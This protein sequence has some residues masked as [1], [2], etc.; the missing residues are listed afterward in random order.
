[1]THAQIISLLGEADSSADT[2]G[3]AFFAPQTSSEDRKRVLEFMLGEKRYGQMVS[4][5][6]CACLNGRVDM[7][8]TSADYVAATG[9]NSTINTRYF[10]LFVQTALDCGISEAKF[11]PMIFLAATSDRKSRLYVWKSSSEWYLSK[12]AVSDYGR[13][14]EYLEKNDTDFKLFSIL[15][16]ADRERAVRDLTELAMFGK[17][18]N[19]VAARKILRGYKSE[20]TAYVR[21]LYSSLKND[22]KVA[23]VR[24]LLTLKNDPDVSAFLS[25]LAQTEKSKSVL[26]LLGDRTLQTKDIG[27]NPDRRRVEA[28]FY[29]A[30]VLGTPFSPEQFKEKLI[31]SPFHE[32]ADKLFF[33]V[34]RGGNLTDIAVVDSGKIF[35]IENKPIE[36]PADCE[37]RVLHPAELN[38]KTEFI[39]RLNIVQPFE[40]VK[41]KVYVASEADKSNNACFG[42]AGMMTEFGEFKNAM[43][44][45]GFRALN[46]DSESFTSQVGICRN[47]ILCVVNIAPFDFSSAPADFAVRVQSVKFYRERDVVRLGGK[48]FVDGVAPLSLAR[49]DARTF[50]EFMYSAYELMGCK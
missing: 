25:E 36:L 34:Y 3:R 26:K 45:I 15:I 1:M 35:D 42:I 47:G 33:G 44:K 40:Q 50:S 27:E 7:K 48:Q 38:Y 39:K 5:M 19:K 11:I 24:L 14:W 9:G 28:F 12:L 37:V 8:K 2:A 6:Y 13:A 18:V 46:R 43:R 10:S 30:M 32:V 49:M 4:L 41:R 29:E 17:G 20:V 21:P 31:L 23:A 16:A 22:G